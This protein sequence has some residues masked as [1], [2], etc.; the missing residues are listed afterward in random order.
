MTSWRQDSISGIQVSSLSIAAPR[1]QVRGLVHRSGKNSCFVNRQFFT[2]MSRFTR[3][4]S[5]ESGITPAGRAHTPAQRRLR[6]GWRLP[7]QGKS[8]TSLTPEILY[9]H[10]SAH[11]SCEGLKKKKKEAG[12]RGWSEEEVIV[13]LFCLRC[14]LFMH[15]V[16]SCAAALG[17]F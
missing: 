6:R 13:I 2:W 3:N 16:P 4:S 15:E 11:A 17:S 7:R 9:R 14:P 10:A 8:S 12:M 5:S 1:I